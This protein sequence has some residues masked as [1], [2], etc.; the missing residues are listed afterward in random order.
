MMPL[1]ACA[2]LFMVVSGYY[3]W[4]APIISKR[5]RQKKPTTTAG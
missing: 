2:L 4:L 1:V 5:R 3:I